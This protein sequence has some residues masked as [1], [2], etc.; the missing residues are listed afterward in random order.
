MQEN[1]PYV[2]DSTKIEG[3]GSINCPR[4]GVEISPDDSSD[5]VYT[6]LEPEL[7]NDSLSDII[8]RCNR[9]MSK[10][11]LVGFGNLNDEKLD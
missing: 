7:K 9:C 10:I 6:V 5:K 8:L 1:Q 2:I 4:C 3:E 11:K